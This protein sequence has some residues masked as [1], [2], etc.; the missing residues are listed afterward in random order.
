[1]APVSVARSM[2]AGGLMLLDDVCQRVGEDEP[3]FGVG[4]DDL[5]RLARHAI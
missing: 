1:M 2:I 4:V 5:D 3:T